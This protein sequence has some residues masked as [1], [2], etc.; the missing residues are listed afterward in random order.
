MILTVGVI[1]I[2]FVW[3]PGIDALN[4]TRSRT[5]QSCIHVCRAKFDPRRD[6]YQQFPED[7]HHHDSNGFHQTSRMRTLVPD[8]IKLAKNWERERNRKERN[9]YVWTAV[10]ELASRFNSDEYRGTLI[11]GGEPVAPSSNGAIIW[12]GIEG[13]F[14]LKARWTPMATMNLRPRSRSR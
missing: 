7:Y 2:V 13:Y 14:E 9:D 4:A 11:Q 1:I 10:V 5:Y 12:T 3:F 6:G 8:W